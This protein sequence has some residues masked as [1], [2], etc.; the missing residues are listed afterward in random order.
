MISYKNRTTARIAIGITMFLFAFFGTA[1]VQLTSSILSYIIE[2]EGYT[3]P[4]LSNMIVTINSL[5]QIPAC[6]LGAFLGRRMD[7]KRWSYFGIACF[8][9]G[10]LGVIL[11]SRSLYL[12]LLCRLVVGFGSGLLILLYTAILPDF[13]EGKGLSVMLGVVTSGGGFWG[14]VFS[15]LAANLCAAYGWKAAYLLHLYALVPLALFFLFVPRKPLVSLPEAPAERGAKGGLAPR[16]FLYSL[17]GALLYLGIQV[18]W[19]STSLWMRD[20]L[21]GTAAQ[22]GIVSGLFSLFSCGARLIF[23]FVYHRLGRGTLPLSAALL[24]LGLLLAAKA[25]SYGAAMAAASLVGAAMGFTAPAC[26][27]LGIEASPEN[28]V[29]AQAVTTIGFAAGQFLSTYWSALAGSL[30]GGSLPGV[31]RITACAAAVLMVTMTV[32][33][34]M[35]KTRRLSFQK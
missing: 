22:I 26:L 6:L 7:K 25:S 8:L 9:A 2:A 16:V 23:G 12:V 28:Q 1:N 34:V 10:S 3:D 11:F 4:L 19:S 30:C 27:N 21:G 5:A 35:E 29:A 15:S 31:F 17:L 33:S 18:I 14:F 20:F 24:A 32:F 13:Y